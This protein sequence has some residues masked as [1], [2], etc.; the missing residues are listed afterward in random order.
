MSE[1]NREVEET[2]AMVPSQSYS[3]CIRRS[4]QEMFSASRSS[5]IRFVVLAVRTDNLVVVELAPKNFHFNHHVTP[6]SYYVFPCH[7]G[8]NVN[9]PTVPFFRNLRSRFLLPLLFFGSIHTLVLTS[10]TLTPPSPLPL[11]PP[12]L[13]SYYYC[14]YI[15]FY[16]LL[17]SCFATP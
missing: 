2:R 4:D 12:F 5:L 13:L 8:N 6:A 10:T 14:L 16:V 11:L 7:I 15:S 9:F 1:A 3:R 17:L